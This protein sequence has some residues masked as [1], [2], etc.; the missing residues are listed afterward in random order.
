MRLGNGLSFLIGLNLIKIDACMLPDQ[1]SHGD[2]APGRSQIDFLALIINYHGTG[3]LQSHGGYE[4]FHQVHHVGVVSESLIQLDHGKFGIVLVVNA[5][6]AE[7]LAHIIDFLEAGDNQ[8]LQIELRCDP[9]VHI[10]IQGVMM[11]RKG[12]GCRAAGDGG[13]DRRFYFQIAP[14]I[15]EAADFGYDP[16]ALEEGFFHFRI[17]ND[18]DFP[19]AVS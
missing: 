5:F 17:G 9:Q 12:T 7:V 13:Q 11:G 16:A 8:S 19:A 10:N 3:N 14:V 15:Q 18:V 6:V 1:I 4:L 2:S